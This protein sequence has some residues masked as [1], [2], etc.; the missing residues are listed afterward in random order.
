ML[1][2]LLANCL[3][4]TDSPGRIDVGLSLS[5]ARAVVAIEDSSPGVSVSE[6]EQLFEPLYRRESSRSRRTG[7]AG[8]GLATCRKI[9]EAHGGEISAAPS[10][11]DGLCIR[12]ELPVVER[13][14][15]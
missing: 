13:E 11:L 8:L 14:D 9:V 10:S 1:Q 7:G 5:G 3:S 15:A 6:C 2:N 4:Y 12:I